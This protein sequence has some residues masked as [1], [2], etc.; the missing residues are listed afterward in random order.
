MSFNVD[1]NEVYDPATNKWIVL[2]PM[3]SK[4]GGLR[5]AL[6]DDSIYVFGDE[7]PDG[8][9]NNNE[10]SDTFSNKW[11]LKSYIKIRW[12]CSCVI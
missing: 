5:S 8:T 1:S 4:R 7:Q 12:T 2:E 3:P 10:K 9:F 11:T 6:V